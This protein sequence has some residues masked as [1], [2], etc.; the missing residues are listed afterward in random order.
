M[1]DLP[2]YKRSLVEL[3][4]KSVEDN[5]SSYENCDIS[6]FLQKPECLEHQRTVETVK[7]DE[8]AFASLKTEATGA[9]DAFNANLVFN[10]FEG[11][12]PYLAADERVWV[13]LTHQVAPAFSFNRWVTSRMSP[14]EKVNSI[15]Y[16]F[17]ARGGQRGLHRNNALASLWW[18]AYVCS[19]NERH[20]L[21]DVLKVVLTLTDFRSSLTGRPTSA[22]VS[23]VFNAITNIVIDEYGK[24]SKPE[25]MEREKYRAWFRRINLSG[26][27]RLYSTMA[28]DD[29]EVLFRSLMI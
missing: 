6:T 10:A 9:A 15:K 12:T 4:H 2:I 1:I 3:L 11:M 19:K 26:G 13:A 20:P 17:F 24:T 27:R 23:G 29:L 21:S 7:V 18:Y 22:R 14:E 8:N 25:I 16:H 5:L 28:E